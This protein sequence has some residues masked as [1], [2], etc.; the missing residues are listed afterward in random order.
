MSMLIKNFFF[1]QVEY[2]YFFSILQL[3]RIQF[4]IRLLI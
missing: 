2:E 1:I 4:L 3:I